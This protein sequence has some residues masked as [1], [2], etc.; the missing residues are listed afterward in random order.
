[1]LRII[2][3]DDEHLA[4]AVLREYLQQD[5]EVEIIAECANGFEAVKAITELS[6]DVVLLDIQ[7]PKLDGFEVVELAGDKTRYIFITAYDQHALK[8]FE[9]HAMDYLLK[10]FTPARLQQALAHVRG[11]LQQTQAQPVQAVLQQMANR[12]PML[13]RIL[14]RDGS[15]VHI[16]ATHKIDYFEAQDDYLQIY[17]EGKSWLKSMRLSELENQLDTQQFVRIHR[18][19]IVN[20]ASVQRIE[21]SNKDSHLAVLQNGSKLPISRSGYQ[22]VREMMG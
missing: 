6:P 19:Y 1:M 18:S 2:I 16:I 17:S 20:M 4:R 5:S 15:K 7:M 13:E 10:P 11:N 21:Q 12:Q 14:I 9:V 8:A 22:K 3:V